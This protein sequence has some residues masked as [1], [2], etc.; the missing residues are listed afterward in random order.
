MSAANILR[1]APFLTRYLSL[2]FITCL[3]YANAL[4]N[5][6]HYDDFHSIVHNERLRSLSA[7]PQFFTDATAFSSEA[8]NAM[9]RPLLLATFAANYAISQYQT[10]SYH[11]LS[12]VLHL[13]CVGLVAAIGLRLLGQTLGAWWAAFLFAIH[14]IN[15]EPLNYISSRSELL[16]GL[17]FLLAF[18]VYLRAGQKGRVPWGWA[19]GAY[20]LALLSK[21]I[22]IVLPAVVVVHAALFG[23][24]YRRE[25]KR[26][27]AGLALIGAAYIVGVW[28]FLARATIDQPVRGYDEQI[29]TQVK[30]LVFYVKML[31]WPSGQSIDHQFL[32]SDSL[33]DPIAAPAFALLLSLLFVALRFRREHPI[34]AFSYAWFLLVLAPSSV[35]PLNVL[36]NEH[37]LYIPG[38]GVYWILGYGLNLLCIRWDR[39]RSRLSVIAL[40][41]ALVLCWVTVQRNAVWASSL[42]LWES[43][44][45]GAPMMARPYVFWAEA[46]EQAGRPGEAIR[47]Y[48]HALRRDPSFTVLYQRLGAVYLDSGR[49]DRAL[50]I[51]TEGVSVDS[52]DGTLWST[53]AEVLRAQGRWEESL[54]AYRRAAELLPEDGAVLNNLGNTYQVLNQ[55]QS[56]LRYHL[57]AD[58]LTPSDA[59]TQVNL[60]NAYAMLGREREALQ[61]FR[62]A[63]ELEPAYGGGWLSL[64]GALERGN[65]IEEA[66]RAYEQAA[67][68]DPNNRPF[69]RERVLLLREKRP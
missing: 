40:L 1:T 24:P 56:A 45:K 54:S 64:G 42:T 7:V 28:Q 12:L 61:A 2:A 13:A 34:L 22:A 37:R 52:T 63:V 33:F 25:T 41:I 50:Q 35:V 51:L 31:L 3:V 48:E 14:P 47:S 36:V 38:L 68:A 39:Y 69:V 53:L 44:A 46:L 21:S 8:E 10:W 60:G 23:S 4:E 19:M 26:L 65:R 67:L 43:A 58:Q 27:V 57:M 17:F 32:V 5:P 16:S 29:W 6:F 18:W 11:L 15:T 62:R 59:P 30:A 66:I 9:Y 49:I 55:P 20:A